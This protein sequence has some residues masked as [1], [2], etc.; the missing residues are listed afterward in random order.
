M[1]FNIWIKCTR[2]FSKTL[3]TTFIKNK[4]QNKQTRKPLDHVST[5]ILFKR[6]QSIWSF[7]GVCH[8]RVIETVFFPAL[9]TDVSSGFS[10]GFISTPLPFIFHSIFKVFFYEMIWFPCHL[11]SVTYTYTVQRPQQI[12]ESFEKAED[13]VTR[14]SLF[15]LSFLLLKI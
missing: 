11:S 7:G 4:K 12:S 5:V 13:M 9:L 2:F 15:T 1:H 14:T 10:L 8:L 3:Y 6:E